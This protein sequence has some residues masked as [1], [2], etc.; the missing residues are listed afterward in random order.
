MTSILGGVRRRI[1]ER[2]GGRCEYCQLNERYAGALHEVS[3]IT[4]AKHGGTGNPDN[5]CLI[6]LPCSHQKGAD[7]ASIDPDSRD[8]MVII[9]LFNPRLHVWSDHFRVVEG[10]IEPLTATGRITVKMLD[11]NN[12]LRVEIRRRLQRIGRY[13]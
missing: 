3:Y 2:A 9:P 7:T 5:L 13:P 11:F 4:P 12:P 1:F 6:C 10:R 8:E